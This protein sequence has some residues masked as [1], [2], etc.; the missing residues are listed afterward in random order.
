MS[1]PFVERYRR[2]LGAAALLIV[3]ALPFVSVALA[4][5]T[6]A[7]QGQELRRQL[8]SRYQVLPIRGGVVL[9][10]RQARRGVRAIE[11]S[12]DAIAINGE[13]VNAQIARDWLGDDARLILPLLD[14][15]PAARRELFGMTAEAVPPAPST[16]EPAETPEISETPEPPEE[17]IPEEIEVE[18]P[19]S[20]EL[21]EAPE[22]V[23]HSGSRVKFGGSI[24]VEKEELAEEAV[25][26]GGSVRV[27]GQVSRDVVAIG[28]PV[29]VNGHVGGDVVSVGSSVYLG[30]NAV[31]EG[32]VSS[33]GGTI[34]R[35]QGSQIHGSTSEVDP[36]WRGPWRDRDFDPPFGPFSLFGASMEAFGSILGMVTLALLTCLTL[37]IAR[38]PLE[39]VDRRL[40]A[41]P[42]KSALVGLAGFLASV[43]L[44]I[45]VLGILFLVSLVLV[46]LLVG[47]LLLVLFPFIAMALVLALMLALVL[48][49]SATVYRVGRWL[50][51]RYGRNFGGPYAVAL[52]GVLVIQVWSVIGHLLS[53]GPGVLDIFASMFGVF[54]GAVQLAAWVVGFGA[55]LLARF[56]AP[57]RFVPPAVVP[58]TIP[59]PPPPATYGGDL[60]LT[61][62]RVWEEPPPEQ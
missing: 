56:G 33:T 14:L 12:G 61:T 20:P 25:A 32:D 62:D 5:E 24:L 40:R 2:R 60:P 9:T 1:I 51:E 6:P 49:Y 8:E 44:I 47:C 48:G 35:S 13:R 50:E 27:D 37:L 36:P 7:V 42:V 19:A 59:P 28:G 10:P 52:V 45:V 17:E 16:P 54:G 21:P 43:P 41:E 58:A 3:F 34:E 31:V 53:W 30:P 29:R 4:Q 57:T 26:I 38:H 23:I 18:T 22:P 46:I 11:V 55:V 39:Q 15:N